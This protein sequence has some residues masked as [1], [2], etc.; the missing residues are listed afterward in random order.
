MGVGRVIAS[1]SLGGVM[2]SLLGS[3][4]Q[5]SC[6]M[7]YI[8]HFHQPLPGS[9]TSCV[10]CILGDCS[11]EVS[12]KSL[13]I[14]Y[15]PFIWATAFDNYIKYSLT[16][17]LNSFVWEMMIYIDQHSSFKQ[18]WYDYRLGHGPDLSSF[19][20]SR[21]RSLAYLTRC[22]ASIKQHMNIKH[23]KDLQFQR[24]QCSRLHWPL[25]QEVDRVIASGTKS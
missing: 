21:K 7:S 5:E 3:E 23:L 4:W 1:E 8:S 24:G 11:R 2:V 25:R 22:I 17:Y 20:Y 13:N 6:S 9:C 15:L 14:S 10:L 12:A 18:R 19:M 16:Y